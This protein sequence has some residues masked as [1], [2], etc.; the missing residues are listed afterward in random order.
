MNWIK[1]NPFVAILAG[2]TLVVCAILLFVGLQ[3]AKK[4]EQAKEGFDAAF[5]GVSRAERIPLYPEDVNRDAK[6]K[7]LVDYREEIS[8]LSSLFDPYRPGE[9][10]PLSPQEFTVRLKAATDEVS[11]A[12]DAAGSEL[13]DGFFLGFES[14]RD[15]LANSDATAILNYQLEGITHAMLD[16]AEARPSAL[17]QI[18]RESIEEESGDEYVPREN[19]ISRNFGFEVVFRGSENSVRKF[20]S[21]LGDTEPYYYVVRSVAIRNDVDTPP[22]V[23]D[24]KF[25]TADVS[26]AESAAVSDPFGGAFVLP[27]SDVPED[28]EEVEATEDP[29]PD[30]VVAPPVVTD[31][32][33]ILAQV[34]GG[35]E[36]TVFVRFDLALLKPSKELPAP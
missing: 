4:F 29:A 12:F 25:E 18:Y 34:L 24:A 11:A 27:G 17:I 6:T 36:L 32:G 31:T 10:K 5:R 20:L 16:L 28:D 8:E 22:K 9:L 23:S 2:V 30:E 7:A 19:A 13:P 14:Y 3:G 26:A 1:A 33:R 15:L 21:S 35:E